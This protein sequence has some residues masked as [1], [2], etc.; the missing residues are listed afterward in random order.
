MERDNIFFMMSRLK[1]PPQARK[2]CIFLFF[3]YQIGNKIVL[4]GNKVFGSFVV[5]LSEVSRS[6]E[7]FFSFNR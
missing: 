4:K 2:S 6:W 7:A 1:K 3:Y 5:L